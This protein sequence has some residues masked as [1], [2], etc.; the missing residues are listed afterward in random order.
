MQSYMIDEQVRNE[1]RFEGMTKNKPAFF[2]LDV[3]NFLV[4]GTW[5][6]ASDFYGLI[7]WSLDPAQD[8]VSIG[9]NVAFD[10][11]RSDPAFM[12]GKRRF[13]ETTAKIEPDHFRD[14]LGEQG[15]GGGETRDILS[16]MV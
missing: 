12:R 16:A 6:L 2:F 14:F 15:I 10:L 4:E 11:I 5:E 13:H 1:L 3:D 7:A 8:D 9:E